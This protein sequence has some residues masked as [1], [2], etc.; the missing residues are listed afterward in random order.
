[1]AW[2]RLPHHWQLALF[3]TLWIAVELV[4]VY[5]VYPETRGPTLE[6]ISRIFDGPEA[7]AQVSMEAVEKEIEDEYRNSVSHEKGAHVRVEKA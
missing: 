2:K 7:V 6:E 4:F 1:V 5:F 3:Y